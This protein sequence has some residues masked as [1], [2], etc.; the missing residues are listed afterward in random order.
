M[1]HL[2]VDLGFSTADAERVQ[3]SF[4]GSDVQLTFVDWQEVPRD[5][6]F[7][8]VLGFSW[9]E[10]LDD[11]SIRDDVVYEVVDSPWL[12]SQ[13]ELNA[14]DDPYSYVHYK[15]CFN[16]CGVLDVLC[17]RDAG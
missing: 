3:L 2:Q 11:S 9:S 6:S 14:I 4:D 10:E 8:E 16:A 1:K 7:L 12:A 17:K 13:L 15:L 5:H